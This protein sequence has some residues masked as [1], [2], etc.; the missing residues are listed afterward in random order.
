MLC[1]NKRFIF[2]VMS[3]FCI[4]SLGAGA[5][6]SLSAVMP[7]TSSTEPA[8]LA[9]Y[10]LVSYLSLLGDAYKKYMQHANI[11]PKITCKSCKQKQLDLGEFEGALVGKGLKDLA[12]GLETFEKSKKNLDG[13]MH[14]L[15]HGSYQAI[16]DYMVLIANEIKYPCSL[17]HDALWEQ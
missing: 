17:C 16:V 12:G 1:A 3:A 4:G 15:S 13:C 11:E 5:Q 10:T 14:V 2:F 8:T 7:S 9:V 6:T